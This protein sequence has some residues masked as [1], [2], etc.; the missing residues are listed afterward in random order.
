MCNNMVGTGEDF[1]KWNNPDIERPVQCD[2]IHMWN[3]KML[4]S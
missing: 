2:L 4:T 1:V 3:L